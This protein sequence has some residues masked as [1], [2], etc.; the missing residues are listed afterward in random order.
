MPSVLNR[1]FSPK[2]VVPEID[3]LSTARDLVTGIDLQLVDVREP[4]EWA[5]GHIEGA[6]LLPLGEVTV[7]A[8]ELDPERPVVVICRSGNRSASATGYLLRLGFRDV[9]NLTGGMIAWAAAGQS[10]T[11]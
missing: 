10:I 4:D 9:R 2:L 6:I 11:R 5:A 1:L 8:R 7:R 3:V